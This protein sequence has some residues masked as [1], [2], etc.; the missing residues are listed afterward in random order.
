M[1]CNCSTPSHAA[2]SCEHSIS[3]GLLLGPCP[4]RASGNGVDEALPQP[5]GIPYLLADRCHTCLNISFAHSVW[6]TASIL[7]GS[8]SPSLPVSPFS[9]PLRLSARSL[10]FVTNRK[11]RTRNHILPQATLSQFSLPFKF[12]SLEPPDCISHLKVEGCESWIL[13]PL[14]ALWLWA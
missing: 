1:I 5:R 3:R 9:V 4:G 11:R 13:D 10:W 14:G 2:L 8:P 6:A 12:T 7:R